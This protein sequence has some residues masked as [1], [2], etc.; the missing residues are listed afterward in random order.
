VYVEKCR[1]TRNA[2]SATR[3]INC[4]YAKF[5][6]PNVKP[7]PI[8]PP[9]IP[10][11]T[12]IQM[13]THT[14][15]SLAHRC[16]VSS[17][18]PLSPCPCVALSLCLS[19]SISLSIDLSLCLSFSFS[20]FLSLSLP[21]FLFLFLSLSPP[22]SFFL[23]PSLPAVPSCFFSAGHHMFLHMMSCSIGA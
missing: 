13:H 9:Y 15:L 23:K 3:D 16:A 22:L 7:P 19:L 5:S 20:L 11:H 12:H 14:L 10:T 1:S 17:A 2:V 18:I 4:T 8:A 6:A 21:R